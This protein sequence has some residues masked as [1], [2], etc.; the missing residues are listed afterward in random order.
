M[1][2]TRSTAAIS[3][4]HPSAATGCPIARFNFEVDGEIVMALSTRGGQPVGSHDVFAAVCCVHAEKYA[5]P[6]MAPPINAPATAPIHK[7]VTPNFQNPMPPTTTAPTTAP[8]NA[9]LMV[10]PVSR[11]RCFPTSRPTSLMNP[12]DVGFFCAP[13]EVSFVG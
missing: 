11:S 9:H 7:P 1:G 5:Q 3:A 6:P 2:Q 4:Q 8:P 13:R 12:S 10:V